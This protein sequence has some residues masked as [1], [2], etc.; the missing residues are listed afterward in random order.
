MAEQNKSP[1]TNHIEVAADAF[2]NMD[3]RQKRAFFRTIGVVPFMHSFQDK[4]V[5]PDKAGP[6]GK[7]IP[8]MSMLMSTTQRCF[9]GLANG[10]LDVGS[11][12]LTGLLADKAFFSNG[13]EQGYLAA[14]IQNTHEH[15]TSLTKAM[16]DADKRPKRNR[17][18]RK[19]TARQPASETPPKKAAPKKKFQ[20]AVAAPVPSPPETTQETPAS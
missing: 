18:A 15:R 6:L 2:R 4:D 7:A 17:P 1:R 9:E 10:S 12:D 13:D 11:A 19:Q 14:F 8:A 16:R 3:D 20:P 5:Y